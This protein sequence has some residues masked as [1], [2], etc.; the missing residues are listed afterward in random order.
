MGRPRKTSSPPA[1]G[2]EELVKGEKSL[3]DKIT[4][5]LSDPAVNIEVDLWSCQDC[6]PADLSALLALSQKGLEQTQISTQFNCQTSHVDF[7]CEAGYRGLER[8]RN[9]KVCDKN[10]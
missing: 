1:A 8:V 2:V 4:Q 5:P 3:P 7:S 10:F 9:P 6:L